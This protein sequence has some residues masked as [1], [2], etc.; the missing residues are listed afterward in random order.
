ML[1]DYSV[2]FVSSRLINILVTHLFGKNEE[3]IDSLVFLTR[4]S[5]YFY[6]LTNIDPWI[7]YINH[8][9]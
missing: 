9:V 1:L 6:L 2:T 7:F 3:H 5:R 8:F 4:I